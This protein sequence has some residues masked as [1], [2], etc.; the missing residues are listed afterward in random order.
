M[1]LTQNVF[2]IG[3]VGAGKSTIGRQLAMTLKMDFFDSDREVE[4]QCGVDRSFQR[5]TET[6]DAYF[7]NNI[8]LT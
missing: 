6:S 3:P 5:I 4:K 7:P 1:I 2:L 8:Q